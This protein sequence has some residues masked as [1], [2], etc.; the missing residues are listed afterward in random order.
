MRWLKT[1]I[2]FLN[3]IA[4]VPNYKRYLA[5]FQKYHPKET[6]LSE[7][8]FHRKATDEKYGS[9]SIRRCC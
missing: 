3:E 5:H 4:G 7:K 6:P 1:I 2:Y 8:D 9:G